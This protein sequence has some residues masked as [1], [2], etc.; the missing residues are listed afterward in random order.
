MSDE[1]C[2]K[3]RRIEEK[4]GENK[5]K[6]I[7]LLDSHTSK[8]SLDDFIESKCKSQRVDYCSNAYSLLSCGD[9]YITYLIE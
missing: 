1:I 9:G 2:N 7:S 5:H 4:I 6:K 8:H 3:K